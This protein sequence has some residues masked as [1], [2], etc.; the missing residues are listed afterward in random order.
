MMKD[1]LNIFAALLKQNKRLWFLLFLIPAISLVLSVILQ[2]QCFFTFTYVTNTIIPRVVMLTILFI[3]TILGVAA[4]KKNKVSFKIIILNII[5]FVILFYSI[6]FAGILPSLLL[7]KV[8][9]TQTCSSSEQAQKDAGLFLKT[10][11]SDV[12]KTLKKTLEK[13]VISDENF[14]KELQ[15]YA[16]K[17]VNDN[18]EIKEMLEKHQDSQN[19]EDN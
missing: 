13:T 11:G 10:Q 15:G 17:L 5:A 1:M 16:D 18:P 6:Q 4:C 2:Q 14:T 7:K 12:E 9:K 19:K 3:F 8:L